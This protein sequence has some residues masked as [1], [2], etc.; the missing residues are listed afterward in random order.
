MKKHITVYKQHAKF[1]AGMI[2]I[3]GLIFSDA[4]SLRGK[5]VEYLGNSY[6]KYVSLAN[7]NMPRLQEFTLCIDLNRTINTTDWTVFTYVTA[8]D[9]QELGLAGSS[10]K[11]RLHH[12]D[13]IHEIENNLM[14]LAWH[15]VCC[16]YDGHNG[17]LELYVNNTRVL[18]TTISSP[19]PLEANGSLILG[20]NHTIKGN[21][22]ELMSSTNFL[23]CLYY[24]QMWDYRRLP[25]DNCL[26]GNIINWK[27]EVWQLHRILPSP[28][29][30]LRCAGPGEESKPP[31]D[32]NV[33]QRTPSKPVKP[34]E[35]TSTITETTDP[36]LTTTSAA[37]V[38]QQT[39]IR[40]ESQSP[41]ATSTF[42]I[43]EN[44]PE[45]TLSTTAPGISTLTIQLDQSS[46]GYLSMSPDTSTSL[47]TACTSTTSDTPAASLHVTFYIIRIIITVPDTDDDGSIIENIS[48]LTEAW[49]N[50][51]FKNTE[52]TMIHFMASKEPRIWTPCTNSYYPNGGNSNFTTTGYSSKSS[53]SNTTDGT[54]GETTVLTSTFNASTGYFT[55]SDKST[56]FNSNIT[57]IIHRVSFRP[58]GRSSGNILAP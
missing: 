2:I 40:P 35:T 34:A 58:S 25:S 38:S 46:P 56:G 19:R 39:E 22:I 36:I 57:R 30:L 47:T 53:R 7:K 37:T 50:N 42:R 14:L 31:S 13:T 20:Y 11:L 12:F 51:T 24:F 16:I 18:N 41:G 17:Q 32:E 49:I 5:K 48:T 3:V 15:T 43:T 10:K 28:D 4:T 54:T 52:F 27:M 8:E 26:E 55:S 9:K 45:P 21:N 1:F 44:K 29:L 23:G 6:N 33:T